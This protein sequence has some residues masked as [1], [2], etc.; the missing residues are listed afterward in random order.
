MAGSYLSDR[1]EAESKPKS[2]M[3]MWEIIQDLWHSDTNPNGYVSLGL[4]ENSLMH[5]KLVEHIHNNISLPAQALTYGDGPPAGSKRLRNAMA[6]FLTRHLKPVTPIESD[7]IF[8]TNGCSSSVEHLSW[9]LANPG[10]GFLLGQ[11]YYGTFIPDISLRPGVKVVPVPFDEVDPV[12]EAA[13]SK[14]EFA[15]KKSRSKG[16]S[17]KGLLLCHP[18]NPLGRCY[19]REALTGLMRL[20]QQYEIHLI[21]DE[22]YAL[23]VWE[24]NI[25][26]E[27]ASV[28]FR[29]CASI[30]PTGLIDP[31]RLHLI[32]GLSKDFGANGLR[33]GA[34]ISQHNASL[35]A[36][37]IPASI[38]SSTSS[39]SDHVAANILED[40]TW[41][42]QYIAENWR[43]LAKHYELVVTWAKTHAIP[44]MPGVNAAFFLWVDLG[45][46]YRSR[47]PA[48]HATAELDER[49][50]QSLLGRRVFLASGK[51]FG[52]EKPG[53][54][55][56]VFSQPESSLQEGLQRIILA[57]DE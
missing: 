33:L 14:Y 35:H 25:D 57:L 26:P 47:H 43:L 51:V 9:A 45:Q 21:S 6:K 56:I 4:A 20:C 22:I 38:Y 3:L 7:H 11:P 36:A 39:L 42:E 8:V 24:N 2:G 52:S 55:R 15:L 48:A 28:P 32:W 23:S 29:S 50:M 40:D 27:P 10:D 37:L 54:F 1:A 53:W 46:A 5:N 19:P 49:I 18:H 34:I 41:V 44:Y 16:V 31:A 17:I 30:D 13:V 12:S